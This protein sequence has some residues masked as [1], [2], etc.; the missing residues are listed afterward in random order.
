ME[1]EGKPQKDLAYR[2]KNYWNQQGFISGLREGWFIVV[3][4]SKQRIFGK[5]LMCAHKAFIRSCGLE[6]LS[7]PVISWKQGG[8]S[9][10]ITIP[11]SKPWCFTGIS[12][13]LA[14]LWEHQVFKW[15]GQCLSACGTQLPSLQGQQGLGTS[16]TWLGGGI[17]CVRAATG[18]SLSFNSPQF[19]LDRPPGHGEHPFSSMWFSFCTLLM[20]FPHKQEAVFIPCFRINIKYICYSHCCAIKMLQQS[21]AGLVLLIPRN[22]SLLWS[23]WKKSWKGRQCIEPDI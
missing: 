6:W 18:L 13:K 15:R 20:A 10:F 16:W 22:F 14:C 7:V 4:G 12:G 21:L 8:R 19:H 3:R 2:S 1:N 9:G 11:F 23:W 17:L 5:G